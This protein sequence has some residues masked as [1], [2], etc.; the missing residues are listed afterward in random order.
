M[1]I[2][3]SSWSDIKRG[4]ISIDCI[5]VNYCDA[6]ALPLSDLG[7]LPLCLPRARQ[8]MAVSTM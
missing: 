6:T 8:W 7:Q 5:N 3:S 1:R 4:Y 2:S